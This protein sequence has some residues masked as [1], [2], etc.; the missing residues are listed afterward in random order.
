METVKEK[1]KTAMEEILRSNFLHVNSSDLNFA[2]NILCPLVEDYQRLSFS[3]EDKNK[4]I[5]RLKEQIIELMK[6]NS[7][8][9]KEI[10]LMGGMAGNP[11]ATDACRLI[12]KKS[13]SVI[14]KYAK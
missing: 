9:L 6:E 4:T 1:A 2:S 13:Q 14:N 11:D 8:L 7:D 3:N 12:S 10:S 5:G